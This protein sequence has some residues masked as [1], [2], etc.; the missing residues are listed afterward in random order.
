MEDRNRDVT[1]RDLVSSHQTIKPFHETD[2]DRGVLIVKLRKGQAIS[3]RCVAKKGTAK[4][5]AKWSPCAGV[6]FEYDPHNKLRHTTYWVEENVKEEWPLGPN[7]Q[8]ELPPA[9]NEPF[10]YKAVANKF[11][12]GVESTGALAPKDIVVSGLDMLERKLAI[13]REATHTAGA[14]AGY[15]SGRYR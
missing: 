7:A 6:A 15:S 13:I 5:H 10:D 8:L 3:I 1:S 9:D 4:E 11:Y 12:F 2:A 14:L